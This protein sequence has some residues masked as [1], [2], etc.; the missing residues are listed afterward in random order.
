MDLFLDPRIIKTWKYFYIE[1]LPHLHLWCGDSE[2][3]GKGKQFDEAKKRESLD[4]FIAVSV[5][6]CLYILI[7]WLSSTNS[8]SD[9][10]TR[11]LSRNHRFSKNRKHL[12]NACGFHES[13]VWNADMVSPWT[14]QFH[15]P[16]GTCLPVNLPHGCCCYALLKSSAQ[17]LCNVQ[18]E[19]CIGKLIR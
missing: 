18:L 15:Q 7:F 11:A 17:R 2:R 4:R 3:L 5:F 6:V 1:V 13:T 8:Y 10:V 19:I 16:A 12:T 14:S 9:T